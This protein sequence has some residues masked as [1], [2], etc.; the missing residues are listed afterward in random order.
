MKIYSKFNLVLQKKLEKNR[1][2]PF[3]TTSLF[4]KSKEIEDFIIAHDNKFSSEGNIKGIEIKGL[5]EL[6]LP[7]SKKKITLN[8]RAD[9]IDKRSSGYALYD[10]KTKSTNI[11]SSDMASYE[12]QLMLEAIIAEYGGFSDCES[13][14]VCEIA[15]VYIRIGE[16]AGCFYDSVLTISMGNENDTLIKNERDNLLEFLDNYYTSSETGFL[17]HTGRMTNYTGDYDHLARVKEWLI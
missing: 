1:I 11:S 10:Y 13:M 16:R 3:V 2:Y 17:S 14:P 15:Y 8:T 6:E 7:F 12:I 5:I 9:R 4:N